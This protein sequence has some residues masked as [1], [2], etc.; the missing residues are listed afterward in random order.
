M[1]QLFAECAFILLFHMIAI[2]ETKKS[3]FSYEVEELN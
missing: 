2:R 1:E 3:L